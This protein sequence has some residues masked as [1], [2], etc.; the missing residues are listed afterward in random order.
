[1]LSA[2]RNRPYLW[3]GVA[4]LALVLLVAALRSDPSTTA[5]ARGA[6]TADAGRLPRASL[7]ANADRVT[8]QDEHAS[9]R[10]GGT[11]NPLTVPAG[12]HWLASWGAS[13]QAPTFQSKVSITG[14]NGQTLRQIVFVTAGG[15]EV[16]IH[17]TNQ[18]GSRPLDIG[19]ASVAISRGDGNVA[20][21]SI[22]LLQFGGQDSVVI[23]A[24]GEVVSD[25]VALTVKALQ[26][27]AITIYLPHATGPAT[28]H[29]QSHV[30]NYL[31]NGEHVMDPSGNVF[32]SKVESWFF[33]DGVDLL[34]PRRYIGAVATLGDSI[35]AG[36][37]SITGAYAN[38]PDDLA[39]RLSALPGDTLSV[40]NEGIGGNRVLNNSEC[41][42]LNAIARFAP[43][44]LDQTGVRDVI[45]LEGV[46]D[47]GYSQQTN[48]LTAP[49]TDVSAAQI[50]AGDEQIIAAAHE[51]GLRIFGA[52]LL[53][54][55]GARYW[56]PAG[57]LKRDEVNQWILGSGDFDGVINFASV[58][59]DPADPLRLNPAFDSGDNLH[60][61]DAGYRA[62]ANAISLELLLHG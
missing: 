47:I 2:V 38:W 24:G 29:S 30:T 34:S 46:N 8:S 35:T 7:R 36:V 3:L 61:N 11:T 52:T 32:G 14:F 42:G 58:V 41:C 9:F 44:V 22:H 40:L 53:P 45:L 18:F 50:I 56:T 5:Y 33:I 31:S 19:R 26:R 20:P 39:R 43:D 15:S 6:R 13:P 4:A 48:P 49:H 60:P 17:F 54:F 21:A 62:M 51:A 57:E 28:E 25:P 16:R 10:T 37:G 12:K 59:A 23:P 1:L 27:L 55:K